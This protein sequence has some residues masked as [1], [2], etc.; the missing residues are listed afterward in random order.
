MPVEVEFKEHF[1]QAG[2][3]H[4]RDSILA[5]RRAEMDRFLQTGLDMR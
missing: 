5:L 4:A 1:S 3:A 2:T